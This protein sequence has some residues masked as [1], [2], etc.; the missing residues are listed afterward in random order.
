[1]GDQ[2]KGTHSYKGKIK[3]YKNVLNINCKNKIKI[4]VEPLK[5]MK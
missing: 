1:M 3:Q 5:I 2:T 4:P